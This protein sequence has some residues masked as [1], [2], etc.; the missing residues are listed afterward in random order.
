VKDPW[1]AE[2]AYREAV[3]VRERVRAIQRAITLPLRLVATADLA[4]AIVVMVIGRFHLLA[5]FAPA[6]IC[7]LAVSGWWYRRYATTH[8]LLLP[9][10][11]WVL[12]L[13][14]TLAAGASMSRLGVALDEPRVSDFGPCLAFAVGTALTA[15]W[16]RS[17]RLA[18][19]A[20][21]MVA[22][23]ALVSLAADGDLAVALQ[24]T[25]FGVLLWNASLATT[26]YQDH[27]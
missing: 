26:E 17:P 11:P 23:T 20:I 21:A 24:L 2:L 14:A 18:L 8:G 27:M 9:V 7:V 16:L 10:R 6:Y 13:V 12:I 5:Y 1:V 25:A 3:A 15:G 4:G 22:S 19:T